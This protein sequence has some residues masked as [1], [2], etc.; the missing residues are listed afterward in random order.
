MVKLGVLY[1]GI[2]DARP[3]EIG[4]WVEELGYDSIWVGDHVLFYVDGLTTAMALGAATRELTVGNAILVVPLRN[5]ALLARSIATLAM[6]MPGRYVLG[7]GAG[8]D[9]PAEFDVVDVPLAGRGARMDRTLTTLRTALD[10]GTLDGHPFER[11]VQGCPPVWFGGRTDR[12]ARRAAD[13][14]DGFIPYLVTPQHY[15]R[16]LE[17]VAELRDGSPRSDR[18]LTRGADVM[19]SVAPTREQAWADAQAYHAY[20]LDD[21]QRRRH[22]VFGTPEDVAEGLAAFVEHGAE[23]LILHVT[24]PP[25]RKRAQ[26]ELLASCLDAIRSLTPTG[27]RA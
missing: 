6:E 15:A 7:A 16:L 12:A 1:Q 10:D 5:P 17:Q 11:P 20:G 18:P 8:G 2:P 22:T 26:I 14:G 3:S 25:D 4:R 24:A 19:V 13:M 9:V 21:E 27:A 23:H